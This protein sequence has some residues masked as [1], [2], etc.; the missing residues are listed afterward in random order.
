VSGRACGGRDR[1]LGPAL[2]CDDGSHFAAARVER[3]RRSSIV[4][5][6]LSPV[7][8]T[9]R[10]REGKYF[11]PMP[12]DRLGSHGAHRRRVTKRKS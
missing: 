5:T 8:A 12:A 2:L 4:A 11:L 10:L 6:A 3:H 7:V 1:K 9:S